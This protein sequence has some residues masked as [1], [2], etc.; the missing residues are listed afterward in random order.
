MTDKRKYWISLLAMIFLGVTFI[1]AGMGKLLSGLNGVD[2]FVVPTFLPQSF[3]EFVYLVLP[4]VEITLGLL[5]ILGLA[6]RYAAGIS[7]VLIA[8]FVLFNLAEISIGQGGGP[9]GGCFGALGGLTA[10]SALILDVVMA[11]MVLV[12]FAFYKKGVK[13]VEPSFSAVN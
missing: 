4:Y 7:A 1:V 10:Y 12:I 9:C 11:V 8:G 2:P 3:M 5:L 6:V 13:C